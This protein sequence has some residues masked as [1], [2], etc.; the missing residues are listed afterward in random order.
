MLALGLARRAVLVGVLRL[1]ET[2]VG[3]LLGRG[4]IVVAVAAAVAATTTTTLALDSDLAVEVHVLLGAAGSL[5]A[6]STRVDDELDDRELVAAG[7][8]RLERDRPGL[9]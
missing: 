8:H 3:A 1:P 4:G 2:P 5:F 9:T 7:I 6:L